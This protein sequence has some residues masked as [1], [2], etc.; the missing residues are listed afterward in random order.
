M[1]HRGK[2]IRHSPLVAPII[3][4][5]AIGGEIFLSKQTDGAHRWNAFFNYPEYGICYTFFDL[6]SPNY[7]GTVQCLFPYLNFHLFNNKSRLNL[8]FR[9]GAGIAYVDKIYNAETNPLNNAFST[10][11][12][13][14]LNAQLQG[15][16][17][18]NNT[19]LFA[20]I[21]ILHLSNGAYRMPNLG[22]NTVSLFTG[23]SQSF[24]KKN[25]FITYEDR[26]NEKNKN[27]DCSV[28]LLGGI[29]EINPIG[30]KTYFAG[31]FNVEVT[32]KHLQYTRFGLGL[33]ITYDASEHDRMFF[34]SKPAVSRLE[35]TRIGISGG[36][37]LLLGVFSLDL[38]FGTYLHDQNTLYSKVYQRTS[39]RYPLSDRVKLSLAFRNHKGKADFI[40]LGFGYRITK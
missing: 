23:I 27:W 14:V 10:H 37:V 26:M 12:N 7:A 22:L 28:F 31:D 2:A 16:Y 11:P 17:H 35:T 3:E 6:G 32:K 39:L 34:Q 25:R 9:T 24:G 5:Q 30:G 1:I 13:I 36:Y 38:Y 15:V 29:K 33:D 18:I 8:Q 19:H 21:G 20:G 4:R 40:G